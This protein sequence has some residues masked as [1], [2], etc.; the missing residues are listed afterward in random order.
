M[1]SFGIDTFQVQQSSAAQATTAYV[2]FLLQTAKQQDSVAAIITTMTPCMRL[3]TFLGQ[4]I[5]AATVGRKDLP[6]QRWVD[7]YAVDE[8]E[9]RSPYACLL[10]AMLV[11]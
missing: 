1:Q 6:Y 4:R 10:D 8:F 11:L 2:D 3:Y 7:A 5:H 9:V